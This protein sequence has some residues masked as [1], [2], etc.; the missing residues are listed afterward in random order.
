[1]IGE[2]EGH[3]NVASGTMAYEDARKAAYT[4]IYQTVDPSYNPNDLF[5]VDFCYWDIPSIDSA[6][7]NRARKLLL[8]AVPNAYAE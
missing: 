3:E 8:E 2:I 6:M 7:F 1:M 4:R 5:L